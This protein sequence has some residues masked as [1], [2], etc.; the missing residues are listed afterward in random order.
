M[1]QVSDHFQSNWWNSELSLHAPALF[2]GR[3]RHFHEN[4]KR[5]T[6]SPLLLQWVKGYRLPFGRHRPPLK[7]VVFDG[8]ST[9][10]ESSVIWGLSPQD[11]AMAVKLSKLQ[12]LGVVNVW[13][14]DRPCFLSS[15]FLIPK[16]NSSEYCFIFNLR[17][18]NK[19]L[20]TN[21]FWLDD[22]RT[23][24]TLLSPGNFATKI[25]LS[26]AYFSVPVHAD[27]YPY[28]TF[29]FLG[30]VYVMTALPMGLATA[31][32]VFHKLMRPVMAVLRTSGI[33]IMNYLDDIAVLGGLAADCLHAT[34]STCNLLTHL[35]FV[36]NYPKCSLVPA[37]TMVFLGLQFDSITM[38]IGLPHDKVTFLTSQVARWLDSP[39]QSIRS[40]ARLI[41]YLVSC[42]PAVRYGQ[43]YIRSLERDKVRALNHSHDDYTAICTISDLARAELQWWLLATAHGPAP[44]RS[45]FYHFCIWTDASLTGWGAFK[46]PDRV[47]GWWAADRQNC[48]INEL[49]LWAIWEALSHFADQWSNVAILLRV[50]NTTAV[51]IINRMG[52]VSYPRLHALALRI[53]QFCEKRNIWLKASYI[54]TGDNVVADA[55]SRHEMRHS[56]WGLSTEAFQSIQLAFFQPDIDLFASSALHQCDRYISFLP[57]SHAQAIDAFTI[58]WTNLAFYC[59]P[60][61]VLIPRVLQKIRRDAACGIVVVPHWPQQP[62]FSLFH[63]LAVSN[64][65]F[66]GPSP[67]LLFSPCRTLQHPQASTLRLMVAILSARP[68]AAEDCRR[69]WSKLSATR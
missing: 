58:P 68:S 62:W 7:R 42:L 18:L 54:A 61:F 12:D 33:T 57:D 32:Y 31:P 8:V 64:V 69:L 60:P 14:A 25:D 4:W 55:E 16:K 10:L 39:T 43:L 17:Q 9:P 59:F 26:D 22:Y 67:N 35:G 41:G 49:E 11:R 13:P 27:D 45:H 53:W 20:V 44:I 24:C 38:S 5:V 6:N 66:L 50:D 40:L 56:E 48:H 29:Q 34:T 15:I 21:H 47:C 2:S 51:A 19:F 3:I 30:R 28:L 36:I 37:Q 1:S 46:P 63:D 65:L 23:F 52:S